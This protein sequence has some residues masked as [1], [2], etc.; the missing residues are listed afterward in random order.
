MGRV[1]H[2]Y[3]PVVSTFDN[4]APT[5]RLSYAE[6][7]GIQALGTTAPARPA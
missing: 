7:P 5:I 4:D 3:Q 1:L 6:T 2:V